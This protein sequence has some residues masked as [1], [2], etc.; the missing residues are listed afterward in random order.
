[1]GTVPKYVGVIEA[2]ARLGVSRM[3][4]WRWMRAGLLVPTLVIGRNAYFDV[5]TLAAPTAQ[6]APGARQ[7]AHQHQQPVQPTTARVGAPQPVQAH[8]HAPARLQHTEAHNSPQHQA[9]RSIVS[10]YDPDLD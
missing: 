9:H 4:L 3:T 8:V 7:Q 6:Q 10:T 1:M 5:G 2:A